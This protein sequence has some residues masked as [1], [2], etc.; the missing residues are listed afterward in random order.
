[1]KGLKQKEKAKEKAE[2]W[3]REKPFSLSRSCGGKRTFFFFANTMRAHPAC[4]LRC[5]TAQVVF[6][7][8][9]LICSA[10]T[11]CSEF[12]WHLNTCEI[13]IQFRWANSLRQN[14]T[15]YWRVK[16]EDCRCSSSTAR[17]PRDAKKNVRNN[18]MLTLK[19]HEE[20]RDKS[21][22]SN[23]CTSHKRESCVDM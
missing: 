1:M 16:T 15:D 22:N 7:L 20:V 19:R 10:L 4:T 8:C 3:E 9:R 23:F 12:A 6:L 21:L 14:Q 11:H 2:K 17:W 18:I 5:H 13:R